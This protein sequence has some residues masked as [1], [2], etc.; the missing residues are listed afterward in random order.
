APAEWRLLGW[1]EREGYPYDL[2]AE[3]QLHAGQLPLDSYRALILS[4]H[5]EYWSR[6]M[7]QQVKE[8]VT[9]RGGRLL[10]LGGNGLNCEVELLEDFRMRCKN[11]MRR[12]N[13]GLNADPSAV[14]ESRL[15]RTVESEANLLGVVFSEAG[16]MTAAPYR[17]SNPD[18]WLFAGTGLK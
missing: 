17:V 1:L 11:D 2:Y 7:Y 14:F 4:V 10:Y 16:V 8:W 13:I 12:V 18:H 5:P 6:A 3:S 15:H 9:H